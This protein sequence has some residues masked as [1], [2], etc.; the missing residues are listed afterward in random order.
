MK[1]SRPVGPPYCGTNISPRRARY[2]TLRDNFAVA[3]DYSRSR[4]AFDRGR[5]ESKAAREFIDRELLEL[6]F[7]PGEVLLRMSNMARLIG[8]RRSWPLQTIARWAIDELTAE[9]AR[10]SVNLDRRPATTYVTLDAIFESGHWVEYCDAHD[11][12][13]YLLREHGNEA[14]GTLVTITIEEARAWGLYEDRDCEC[15]MHHAGGDA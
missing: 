14:G 9:W 4:E 11:V 2:L 13:A 1:L 10:S 5:L 12:D 8:P 6:P 3:I 15:D 7:R